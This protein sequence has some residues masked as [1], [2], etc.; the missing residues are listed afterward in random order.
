[1]AAASVVKVIFGRVPLADACAKGT[2]AETRAPDASRA[3]DL[4]NHFTWGMRRRTPTSF[5]IKSY[6]P[7]S[8]ILRINLAEGSNKS[9]SATGS[10]PSHA[11]RRDRRALGLGH[12]DRRRD[13]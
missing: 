1:V 8:C 7:I 11:S 9:R 12:G 2:G 5:L 6:P 13:R 4:A 3:D 10:S